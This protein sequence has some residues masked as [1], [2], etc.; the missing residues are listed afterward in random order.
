MGCE[1]K[2]VGGGDLGQTDRQTVGGNRLC[3]TVY[4][5]KGCLQASFILKSSSKMK[6]LYDPNS[7][8]QLGTLDYYK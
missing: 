1:R 6:V 3:A 2:E 5:F 8:D 7:G 4:C